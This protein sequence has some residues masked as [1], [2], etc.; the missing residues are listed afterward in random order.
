VSTERIAVTGVGAVSALGVGARATFERLLSGERAVTPLS[1]FE[2]GATRCRIAAEVKG[3]DLAAIAPRELAS[4]FTRSDALA[5]LAAREA[6]A[7]ARVAEGTGTLGLAIGATT[8]G[9]FETENDLIANPDAPL[10]VRALRL[11]SHPLSATAELLSATLPGVVQSSTVCSACSSS[12]VA[13]VRAAA[14]LR[15]GAV[16]RVLAGGADGLSR[17]TFLGFD[18]LGALDPEP[19]R[20]FDA[21]RRGLNLG[22]GAAFLVLERESLARARGAHVIAFFS[23][24]AVTA[25]AHHI[26]HPEP[27]GALAAALLRRA[28]ER[29]ALAPGDVGYVNAHG[30]GTQQND[31]MEARAL[32]AV[33]GDE[34]ARV[35]I[36]SSKAQLGHTLG[37][38]GAL[39]AVISVLSLER[40]LAPPTAGL[41]QPE[42]ARISHVVGA[43]RAFSLPAAVSC[44]FGFGG[45]GSVLVFEGPASP[46]RSPVRAP[47]AR[48]VVTGRFAIGREE[49][50][51]DPSKQ[52]NPE[53]SRRF[54]REAAWPALASSVLLEN[55]ALSPSGVSVVLGTAY[56]S[57]ER[58]VRFLLRAIASG[59]RMVSPAEFPHLVAS[60]ASG[61]VSIYAGLTG[62]ALTVV[63]REAPH[64]ES[65]AT[66]ALLLG[67]GHAAA[68]IAGVV[69]SPDP[70][71]DAVLGG[72]ARKR[73]E[74]GGFVLLETDASAA[75]RG[76]PVLAE[77]VGTW[78]LGLLGAGAPHGLHPPSSNARSLVLEGEL[79]EAARAFLDASS[80]GAC[81]RESA[82]EDGF[83][84]AV[85]AV[86]TA[87]A[88][89]RLAAGDQDEI[90]IA[91]A[92]ASVLHLSLW[93][94]PRE[95]P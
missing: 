2:P 95:H 89:D 28:L 44:S 60:A 33:F 45:T 12:A 68:A 8:G 18:S 15:T 88:V 20:P 4:R 38:A 76:V 86:A 94:A 23:G 27:S 42:D 13:L 53:R 78:S 32:H 11:L 31:A 69:S 57:V 54:N 14:L 47:P 61:N 58:S 93:R 51:A 67:D 30:T 82:L 55:A 25:E 92:P 80:W 41:E 62:P 19:C 21:S 64:E 79:S 9:M 91:N 63:E 43:A 10:A 5:L 46:P 59:A 37:A 72:P 83:H 77:L 16:D 73:V 71:T 1:L 49:R 65:L 50:D 84:E 36:S 70:I 24:C 6:L 34:I 22:E 90:L 75:S 17:L 81:A 40:G 29:A 74:G 87:R 85:T 52:L 39:E 3:L 66:A 26:T 35:A 48:V 7:D 56:G